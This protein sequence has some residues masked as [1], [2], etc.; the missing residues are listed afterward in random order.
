[1]ITDVS[2]A[3]KQ[4]LRSFRLLQQPDSPPHKTNWLYQDTA[5]CRNAHPSAYCKTLSYFQV[6]PTL[7]LTVLHFYPVCCTTAQENTELKKLKKKKIPNE[8]YQDTQES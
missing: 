2:R 1:M 6:P 8:V 7:I 5:I 4:N 3:V